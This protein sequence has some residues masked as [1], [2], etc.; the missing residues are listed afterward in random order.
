MSSNPSPAG[1]QASNITYGS[2]QSVASSLSSNCPEQDRANITWGSLATADVTQVGSGSQ[3]HEE[4]TGFSSSSRRS[5]AYNSAPSPSPLGGKPETWKINQHMVPNTEIV[6]AKKRPLSPGLPVFTDKR[7][8]RGEGSPNLPVTPSGSCGAGSSTSIVPMLGLSHAD[9]LPATPQQNGRNLLFSR[10]PSTPSSSRQA[11]PCPGTPVWRHLQHLNAEHQASQTGSPLQTS[12]Q[13][14]TSPIS[15]NSSPFGASSPLSNLGSFADLS[16]EFQPEVAN[17]ALPTIHV[18]RQQQSCLNPH[19]GFNKQVHL[20]QL[21]NFIQ[22]IPDLSSDNCPYSIDELLDLSSNALFQQVY[23]ACLMH[24]FYRPMDPARIIC[25]LPSHEA[26]KPLWCP[27]HNHK[28][29]APTHILGLLCPP[30]D[31]SSLLLWGTCKLVGQALL[32]LKYTFYDSEAKFKS[33]ESMCAFQPNIQKWIVGAIPD[34][35]TVT[36][37]KLVPSYWSKNP[38]SSSPLEQ[39]MLFCQLISTAVHE[40]PS[41]VDPS[42]K[43]F[44][45]NPLWAS[46][47]VETQIRSLL[48]QVTEKKLSLDKVVTG[49]GFVPECIYVHGDIW[50]FDGPWVLNKIPNPE[51]EDEQDEQD[52]DEEVEEDFQNTDLAGPAADLMARLNSL[53][54]SKAALEPTEESDWYITA[55]DGIKYQIEAPSNCSLSS[56]PTSRNRSSTGRESLENIPNP[57]ERATIEAVQRHLSEHRAY[58]HPA[59][60]AYW[61]QLRESA[62]TDECIGLITTHLWLSTLLNSPKQDCL[63]VDPLLFDQLV[64]KYKEDPMGMT[65]D[66]APL[67]FGRERLWQAMRSTTHILALAHVGGVCDRGQLSWLLL[68]LKVKSGQVK[69]LEVLIPPFSTFNNEAFADLI[70]FFIGAL[71]RMLPGPKFMGSSSRVR[72]QTKALILPETATA[73]SI[74]LVLLAYL[75]GKFL[76]QEVSV[77]DVKTMRQSLCYYYDQ[78]LQFSMVDSS[79]PWPGLTTPEGE[80]LTEE[81]TEEV[82]RQRFMLAS[83]REPSPFEMFPRCRSYATTLATPG[84]SE[85]FFLEL[86][87][88]H[89]AH[90]E[91]ILLGTTGRSVPDLESAILLGPYPTFKKKFPDSLLQVP[92]ALSLDEYNQIIQ[93]LGGPESDASRMF[94][95]LAKHNEERIKLDWLKDA[96]HPSPEQMYAGFDLDSLSLSSHE[97]PELL[98][99][100]TY[101]PHPDPRFSLT[102]R[103]ELFIDLDG[104]RIGMHT[105]PNFCIMAFGGNNQF[106]LIV[107]FPRCQNRVDNLWHNIPWVTEK[108]DWYHMFLTALRIV[109][110]QVPFSWQHAVEKVIEALPATYQMA[111]KQQNKGGGYNVGHSIDPYIMN[112][113]FKVMRRIINTTPQLVQYRDYFFHLCGINLKLATMNIHGRM[114]DDP[115]KYG[116]SLY[117]FIDWCAQNP[118]DI[119]A[120]IG[121]TANI[122]RSLMPEDQ[123]NT[124]LLF[125][126]DPLTELARA[127]YVKPETD[128]YCSSFVVGGLRSVPWASVH[129]GCGV[130]KMQAYPKDMVLTY[131]HQGQSVGWNWSVKQALRIGNKEK[132]SNQMAGFRNVMQYADSYGVR[133]EIRASAW[134]ANRV[135]K[136]DPRDILDRL[137]A[138]QAIVCHAFPSAY[139]RLSSE[140]THVPKVCYPT[141]TVAAFKSNLCWGWSAILNKQSQLP[142]HT[143]KSPEV[144]L[145]ASVLAYWLKSLI[146]RPDEQG[147]STQMAQRLQLSETA[148]EYG[149]PCLR[150]ASL[151]NDGLRMAYVVE[152]ERFDVLALSGLNLQPGPNTQDNQTLRAIPP[153]D[154]LQSPPPS[155]PHSPLPANQLWSQASQEFLVKLINIHLPRALWNHFPRDRLAD[156]SQGLQLQKNHFKGNIGQRLLSP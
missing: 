121:W 3:Y 88:S 142:I 32:E 90:S 106:R 12:V 140:L 145:L 4:Q 112:R 120:D 97:A 13:A 48:G 9:A 118:H 45:V 80:L 143:R 131:R 43:V 54:S 127:A 53:E 98:K 44:P 28:Q 73:E 31:N 26:D 141:T 22:G 114:D 91:G 116:L 135:M 146:K 38:A 144:V 75:L 93:E 35:H 18:P 77:V 40:L 138:A 117:D 56:T 49:K 83:N 2:L 115:L 133:F 154:P 108:Q 111:C 92:E 33:L 99:F 46:H 156:G 102:T 34:S 5:R 89:S 86:A 113:V 58:H 57:V 67:L 78:A 81:N 70:S 139:S 132:F 55:S 21:K 129:N 134:G 101:F 87:Q 10:S 50:E 59:R 30:E 16:T 63:Y 36:Q 47:L 122:N 71:T 107:F 152:A 130:V 25:L 124:T 60:V 109:S 23:A 62:P 104:Q 8:K 147:Y 125:R 27:P 51:Q 20:S 52:Q 137:N 69:G 103:N 37:C 148:Q 94:F 95:L 14:A 96:I 119:V 1:S 29:L 68:D 149:I 66:N 74:F 136:M 24:A 6:K 128:R 79:F 82:G 100:G 153:P 7:A 110:T 19:P 72:Q 155:P 76:D 17:P 15:V 85:P 84:P 150:S 61:K 42:H 41:N 64:A 39:R 151:D 126:T 11:R 105:C 65:A 123:Q